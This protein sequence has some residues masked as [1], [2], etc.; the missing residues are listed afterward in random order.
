[1]LLYWLRPAPRYTPLAAAAC[2]EMI[3]LPLQYWLW[4]AIHSIVYYAPLVL[5]PCAVSVGAAAAIGWWLPPG[6]GSHSPARPTAGP[7]RGRSAS[8]A[9]ASGYTRRDTS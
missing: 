3:L 6:A 9:T 5:L 7:R 8:E 1:M 4:L 2:T